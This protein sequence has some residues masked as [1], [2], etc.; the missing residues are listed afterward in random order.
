MNAAAPIAYI[1]APFSN[2]VWTRA[3]LLVQI[4]GVPL[5][6]F[7][8]LGETRYAILR[9]PIRIGPSSIPKRRRTKHCLQFNSAAFF[10]FCGANGACL[11]S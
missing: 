1:F 5:T 3:P 8:H 2:L 7:G 9:Y 6:L 11:G 10:L 4:M